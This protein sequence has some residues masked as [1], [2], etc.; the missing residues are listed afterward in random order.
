MKAIKSYAEMLKERGYTLNLLHE[1]KL[2]LRLGKE[3]QPGLLAVFGPV[4]VRDLK[5]VIKLLE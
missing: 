5:A 2:L 1:G 3:A 4:E